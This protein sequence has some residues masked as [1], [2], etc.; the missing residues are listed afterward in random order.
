[1]KFSEIVKKLGETA[2][3]SSL[4]SSPDLDP[5]IT[6]LAAIDEATPGTISYIE[7]AKFAWQPAPEIHQSAVIHESAK[8]GKNVYI[9]A[10]VVIQQ[11]VEIGDNVC[12]HPN[13]TIYPDV[14]IGDRTLLHANCV[15]HERSRIGSDCTIHSGTVIGAEGFGFVPTKQVMF[16]M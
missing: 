8:I 13:V 3:N 11:N 2:I 10:H 15:I 1:M 5:E 4:N 7:G 16:I 12:I 9:G 14:K 6:A